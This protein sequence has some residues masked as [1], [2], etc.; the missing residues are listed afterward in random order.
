MAGTSDTNWRSFVGPQDNGKLITSEDWQAPSDPKQWDDLFKCSNVSNLSATGLT[1]PS[2]REDSIDCVR[3]NAYSFQSC[4]IQGSVTVKG[5][6]EGFELNN[7]VIS[8][9][10]E[11]GQ[12][13]NYWVKGRAPTRNVRL[14][15]CCSPD[16]SPIRI[17]IWDA[18]LSLIAGTSVQVTRIP[19]WIWLPY[20]LFRRLTN[21]KSV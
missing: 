9:T 12:Y 10:V 13:D 14:V 3:G 4:V 2:S 21:L 1:I 5:A 18:E 15:N 16:G 7:C 8:G 20:F 17:K 19:K 6:I 11:L